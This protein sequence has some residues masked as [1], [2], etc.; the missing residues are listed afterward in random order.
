M[1]KRIP[2]AA[3]IFAAMLLGILVGY[4]I[5]NHYDKGEA[6]ELAGY[7][8]IASDLFLRLIKMVI[9][10]AGVLDPGGGIAH[11]G[12][13]RW[14]ASSASRWPGSSSLRWCRWRWA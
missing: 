10:T 8:S 4:L 6:K 14:A 7:I 2:Q 1:K 9:C 5:F 11:M 3:Y 13:S 12:A